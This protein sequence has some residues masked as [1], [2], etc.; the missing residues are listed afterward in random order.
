MPHMAD[1][2]TIF[3]LRSNN[4]LLPMTTN[5]AIQIFRT[6]LSG[7]FDQHEIQAMTRIVFDDI[8]HYSPVDMIIHGSDELPDFM[9]QKLSGIVNRLA[10]HEPLQYILGEARF[11]GHKF[12]V[13]PATLIPRPETD[14]L[15]DIIVDDNASATDLRVLDIGT[16]SGCIAISLALALKF[17]HVTANDIS[18]AALAVAQENA[19]ALKA[20]VNFCCADILQAVQNPPVEAF[21]I[22]VSNPPYI[23]QSEISGMEAHVTDHEPHTALFVPDDDPLRFYKAIAR[24]A[25]QALAHGGKLYFEI[26]SRFGDATAAL[27]RSS[28]FADVNIGNDQYGLPRFATATKSA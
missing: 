15:V 20:Q 10:A 21:D 13:T 9:P 14:M 27:L 6:R 5:E 18:P 17:P 11:H 24:Y 7:I 23:C 8:M 4:P 25:T 16:G 3:K 22:I 26:N 12:R 1:R 2:R 19:A 28:G